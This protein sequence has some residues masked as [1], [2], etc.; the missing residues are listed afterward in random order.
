MSDPDLI[1]NRINDLFK[2]NNSAV[3]D[4]TFLEDACDLLAESEHVIQDMRARAKHFMAPDIYE[5]A[6]ANVG[7][8]SEARKALDKLGTAA[9]EKS[10]EQKAVRPRKK[11]ESGMSM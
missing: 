5:K 10:P 2:R 7:R 6:M 4:K 3:T 1:E 9:P 11:R 8:R